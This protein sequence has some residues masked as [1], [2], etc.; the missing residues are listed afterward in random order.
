MI[1]FCCS[2]RNTTVFGV[3]QGRSKVNQE[4]KS[5]TSETKKFLMEENLS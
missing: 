2:G 4:Q 5:K 1:P 3:S